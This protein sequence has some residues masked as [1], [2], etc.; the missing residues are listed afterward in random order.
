MADKA[1]LE[2]LVGRLIMDDQFRNDFFAAVNR[3][4][5][6]GKGGTTNISAGNVSVN[7]TAKQ[8]ELA[9]QFESKCLKMLLTCMNDTNGGMQ[10]AW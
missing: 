1:D 5:S 2:R 6:V 4:S 3:A 9:Q 7:L 10:E 8:V